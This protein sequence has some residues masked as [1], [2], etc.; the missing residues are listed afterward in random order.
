MA[1]AGSSWR[2]ALSYDSN[3]SSLLQ[4]HLYLF[5]ASLYPTSADQR[6]LDIHKV[7]LLQLRKFQ[8][9]S[10]SHQP[11][12][13]YIWEDAAASRPYTSLIALNSMSTVHRLL[14]T[15]SLYRF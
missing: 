11:Y 7:F 12:K 10:M 9:S 8:S 14:R 6:P 13:N 5:V 3:V 1:A 4:I 15:S 2:R